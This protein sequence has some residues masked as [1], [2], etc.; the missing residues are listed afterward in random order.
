[1][2]GEADEPIELVV[3]GER[4]T[5][6]EFQNAAK[7]HERIRVCTPQRQRLRRDGFRGP[8]NDERVSPRRQPGVFA[9]EP[10]I[11]EVGIANRYEGPRAAAEVDWLMTVARKNTV[12]PV[13]RWRGCFGLMAWTQSAETIV[14]GTREPSPCR[15]EPINED[16]YEPG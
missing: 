9:G 1:M 12:L 10:F 2:T 3:A 8:S 7:D 16:V 5:R 13:G 14:V 11:V 6:F 15:V 4:L